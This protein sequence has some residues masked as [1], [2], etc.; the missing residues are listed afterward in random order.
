MA[1][2]SKMKTPIVDTWA[3]PVEKTFIEGVPEVQRLMHIS[4]SPVFDLVA[5]G[6]EIRKILSLYIIY[7]AD[8]SAVSNGC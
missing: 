4:N 2:I 5:K 7:R 3:Q 8:G 6:M 1:T